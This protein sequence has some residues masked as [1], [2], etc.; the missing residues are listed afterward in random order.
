MLLSVLEKILFLAEVEMTASN[1]P[2]RRLDFLCGKS[3]SRPQAEKVNEAP[4]KNFSRSGKKCKLEF[5]ER[6][7][8]KRVLINGL[9]ELSSSF[10]FSR[11]R[12]TGSNQEYA[13]LD[14]GA[15]RK[16]HPYFA[17]FS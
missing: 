8:R 14:M 13:P 2:P 16:S 7:T 12:Q 1:S 6:E 4:V 15:L 3:F 10:L 17:F 11:A 9:R 5:A